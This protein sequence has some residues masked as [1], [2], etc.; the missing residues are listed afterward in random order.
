MTEDKKD[1]AVLFR[2]YMRSVGDE[3]LK[4]KEDKRVPVAAGQVRVLFWMPEEYVLIFHIEE[5][6][7]VHAVPLTI[8]TDLTTSSLKI[9]LISGLDKTRKILAPLPFYVYLRKEVLE[10]ESYPIYTVRKD[11]IEKVLKVVERAPTWSS[12]KP[13]REFIKLVWKRYSG[14][15]LGS[16]LTTHL[17]REKIKTTQSY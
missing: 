9:H 15:T 8:W 12:I 6:G 1:L 17:Q 10:E 2:F 14:L 13:K 7:L 5:E 3:K 11:T 16:I 4:V